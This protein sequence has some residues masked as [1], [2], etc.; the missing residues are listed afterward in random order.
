MGSKSRGTKTS[1][2]NISNIQ[3]THDDDGDRIEMESIHTEE[4]SYHQAIINQKKM[5]DAAW[6]HWSAYILNKY[7]CAEN[8]QINEDGTIVRN[9]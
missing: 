7:K 5:I 8:D 6:A 1:L 9:T 3:Q 4:V 2:S